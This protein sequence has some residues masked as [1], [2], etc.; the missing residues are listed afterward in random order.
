M[1]LR[2][3]APAAVLALAALTVAPPSDASGADG[4]APA[5]AS[6]G[7]HLGLTW[8]VLEPRDASVHVGTDSLGSPYLGDT[9]PGT[10]LPVL[11]IRVDGRPA[12]EGIPTSGR[13]W[14]AID[15]QPANP[16]S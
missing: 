3:L 6:P 2:R 8:T 12:P 1:F 9:D 7:G 14:T 5:A 10:E 13:F 11:C 15:H 4:P 16:W